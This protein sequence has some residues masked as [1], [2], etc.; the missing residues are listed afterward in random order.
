MIKVEL[1]DE[2][3]DGLT[4]F[5]GIATARAEYLTGCV[6]VQI[7]AQTSSAAPVEY[8]VDEQR[9]EIKKRA[10]YLIPIEAIEQAPAGSRNAPPARHP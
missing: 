3:K 6:R 2:V 8:W 9:L 7:E 10:V 1:G 5:I 4:G